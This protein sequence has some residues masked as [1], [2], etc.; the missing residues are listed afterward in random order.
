MKADRLRVFIAI[1]LPDP[2][3][4]QIREARDHLKRHG[5]SVKWVRSGNIHLT[6]KFLGE[7]GSDTV[8]TIGD[9]MTEAAAQSVSFTLFSKGMGVF[10][11]IRRARVLWTGLGGEIK[12]LVALQK[13][14]DRR[15]NAVGYRKESRP[16]TGHLTIGR[17]K[18]RL[19]KGK[20]ESAINKFERFETQ[21]FVVDRIHLI[22]SEL[23]PTGAV[24]TRIRTGR[25][26]Q[27]RRQ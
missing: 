22:Q 18:G 17:A 1:A 25:L 9:A 7:V 4:E 15:L 14:V 23:K 11:D 6:L 24:Y 16:F 27:D 19:H 21:P 8:G 3:I 12:L 5:F 2:V 20:L 13:E 10:P 26:A